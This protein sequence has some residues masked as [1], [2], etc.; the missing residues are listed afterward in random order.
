MNMEDINE[1]TKVAK[2]RNRDKY[3]HNLANDGRKKDD[4]RRPAHTTMGL[5]M[6]LMEQVNERIYRYLNTGYPLLLGQG[7]TPV[8][9][10]SHEITECPARPRARTHHMWP[11]AS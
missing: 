4:R 1:E 11:W 5:R 10:Q 8:V 2:S 7:E 6:L 3:E 9:A